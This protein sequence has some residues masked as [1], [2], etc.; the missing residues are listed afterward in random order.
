[1]N[2]IFDITAGKLTK[3]MLGL[4]FALSSCLYVPFSETAYMI[5]D[6][7]SD[8]QFGAVLKRHEYVVALFINMSA[9]GVEAFMDEFSKLPTVFSEDVKFCVLQTDKAKRL[10]RQFATYL[11]QISFFVKGEVSYS[12]PFPS[13]EMEL[14]SAVDVFLR[15]SLPTF[16]DAASVYQSFGDTAYTVI[17]PPNLVEEGSD[18]VVQI[19]EN[20]GSFNIIS[21]TPETIK[22]MGYSGDKILIYRKNDKIIKEVNNYKEFMAATRP[23]FYPKVDIEMATQFEGLTALLCVEDSAT[24]EQKEQIAALGA[25]Y[26][27]VTFG[28]INNKELDNI[29][30]MT[31]GKTRQFPC[32]VMYY[33]DYYIY[34]P[35]HAFDSTVEDFIRS[36]VTSQVEPI[37]PSEAVPE[38]QEDPYAIKVVGSNYEEFVSDKE[39][40]VIMFFIG[41]DKDG[42]R[43]AHKIAKY[44]KKQNVTGIKVGYIITTINSCKNLF[45]RLVF[46]PQINFFP[47]HDKT[48]DY[49]H[50]GAPTVYGLLEGLKRFSK[51]EIPLNM[52][53]FKFSLELKYLIDLIQDIDELLPA[54]RA[55]AEDFIIHRGKMIGFGSNLEL[56]IN[57]VYNAAGGFVAG[58]DDAKIAEE[59]EHD[60]EEFVEPEPEEELVRQTYPDKQ[61]RRHRHS[62]RRHRAEGNIYE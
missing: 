17:A 8:R 27:N 37:F 30:V 49:I 2:E 41:S 35:V 40:D 43:Q 11:P 14:L 20:V 52:S 53:T 21:A 12:I 46:E 5:F 55:A 57:A 38:K 4:L 18:Y 59:F 13:T 39:N 28:I 61:P 58:F 25:K 31:S 29:H 24:S 16:S 60:A 23:T 33:W 62:H 56:I 26:Q 36:V 34:Y 44:V 54:D 6:S 7:Y 3:K 48:P 1:M 32:L 22:Q 51:Q 45:P 15:P 42:L 47:K 19:S 10:T 9:D 50:Y